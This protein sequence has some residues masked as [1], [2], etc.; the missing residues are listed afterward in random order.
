MIEYVDAKESEKR[1]LNRNRA[2]N[3]DSDVLQGRNNDSSEDYTDNYRPNTRELAPHQLQ[4]LPQPRQQFTQYSNNNYQPK[5]R[6]NYGRPAYQPHQGYAQQNN[7][8]PRYNKRYQIQQQQQQPQP[9]PNQNANACLAVMSTYKSDAEVARI[10]TQNLVGVALFDNIEIEYLCDGGAFR[11]VISEQAFD[12][13]KR[14][15]PNTTLS[16][17]RGG[18]IKS[19]NAKLRV[20]GQT[21]IEKSIVHIY[22]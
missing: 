16:S 11:T 1:D 15:S 8:Q 13:I 12:K 20:L 19:A 17:Y 5:Y 4:A 21:K 22:V 6:N 7:Y 18:P 2:R 14:Y 3:T 10:T 9:Q